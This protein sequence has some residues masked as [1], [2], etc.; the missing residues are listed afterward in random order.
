MYLRGLD[1]FTA[2]LDDVEAQLLSEDHGEWARAGA[3]GEVGGFWVW[4]YGGGQLGIDC[5][6][7]ITMSRVWVFYFSRCNLIQGSQSS[8]D[9]GTV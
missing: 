3:L 1:D 6:M 4:G 7:T 9:D 8:N 2:W 5:L